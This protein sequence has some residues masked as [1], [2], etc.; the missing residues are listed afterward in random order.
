M[1][2]AQIE[3]AEGKKSVIDISGIGVRKH[4]FVSGVMSPASPHETMDMTDEMRSLER[5]VT[6]RD[7]AFSD[8]SYT[9]AKTLGKQPWRFFKRG[10]N[11]KALN[12]TAVIEGRRFIVDIETYE[13]LVSDALVG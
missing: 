8:I 13:K 2:K 1:A 6:T 7:V 10:S 5:K 12:Y 4:T 3:N 9:E 11:G